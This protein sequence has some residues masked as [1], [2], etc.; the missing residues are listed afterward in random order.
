[1]PR[2]WAAAALGGGRLA[3]AALASPLLQWP[4]IAA[5]ACSRQCCQRRSGKPCSL[6]C[7]RATSA[8]KVAALASA[9]VA[10]A[11]LDRSSLLSLSCRDSSDL[12]APMVASDVCSACA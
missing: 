4:D 1:M 10:T 7:T 12:M 9:R 6:R 3:A 11:A 8:A 2:Q 5:K